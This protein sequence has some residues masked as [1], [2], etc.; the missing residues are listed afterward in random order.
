MI[1]TASRIKNKAKKNREK[2]PQ[3]FNQL[4]EA[5]EWD[6]KTDKKQ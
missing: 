1:L 6:S 3:T 5:L 2:K 4:T